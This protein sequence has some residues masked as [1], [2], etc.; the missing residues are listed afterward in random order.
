V[1]SLYDLAP[2]WWLFVRDNQFTFGAF[3]KVVI[4][5]VNCVTTA[6]PTKRANQIASFKIAPLVPVFAA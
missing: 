6:R 5:S 3:V 4:L 1:N 2:W